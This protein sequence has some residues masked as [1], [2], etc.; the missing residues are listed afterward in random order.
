MSEEGAELGRARELLEGASRVVVLTGAGISTDSGIPDFRGPD[1]IWTRDPEAE[2]LSNISAYLA[3]PALRRRAWIARMANPAWTAEPNDGHRSLVTLER[4]GRLGLLVTQN[5]DGLHVLAG[6]DPAVVVEAHGTVR[7]A[8]CVSCRWR[9]PMPEV[10]ER[11]RA[12]EEDPPCARCGGILKSSTVYFGE[13][14]DPDAVDRAFTAARSADLLLAIGTT[15]SVHPI[16]RMVPLAARSGASIVIVNA[17]PTDV[18]D[19]A[20]VRLTGRISEVLAELVSAL[21][22]AGSP[23]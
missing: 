15:L 8:T 4:S 19:L 6:S 2:K 9:G 1:G 13:P 16:A 23:P 18:D 10:L 20:D 11:V 17:G 22:G 7:E 14:L 21:P 12:G 5:I 3:D